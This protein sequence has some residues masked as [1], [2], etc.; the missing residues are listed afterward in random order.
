MSLDGEIVHQ[1]ISSSIRRAEEFSARIQ[2]LESHYNHLLTTT[3]QAN[4]LQPLISELAKGNIPSKD[5]TVTSRSKLLKVNRRHQ[6]KGFQKNVDLQEFINHFKTEEPKNL[7][8]TAPTATQDNPEPPATGLGGISPLLYPHKE[9]VDISHNKNEGTK[10]LIPEEFKDRRLPYLDKS[11]KYG[12]LK[13]A[14]EKQGYAFLNLTTEPFGEVLHLEKSSRRAESL[15][16]LYRW[17]R[18]IQNTSSA[19]RSCTT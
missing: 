11:V 14:D 6:F 17:Q 8:E 2:D 12:Y 13:F 9:P 1:K 4:P 15:Q 19:S 18:T 5:S 10:I 16:K 3:Q 7:L